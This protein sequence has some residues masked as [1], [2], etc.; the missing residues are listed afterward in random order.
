[1]PENNFD[2]LLPAQRLELGLDRLARHV[3]RHPDDLKVAYN[4][5]VLYAWL[6]RGEEH[7][8]VGERLMKTAAESDDVE[9]YYLAAKAFL[10]YPSGDARL[11]EQARTL[12][13]KATASVEAENLTHHVTRQ[14][15]LRLSFVL[16]LGGDA[17]GQS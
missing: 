14:Q 15:T 10:V 4:L 1:M 5:A 2:S 3:Q 13:R 9:G 17:S 16:R 12:A 7:H 8:A 11:I 6:D